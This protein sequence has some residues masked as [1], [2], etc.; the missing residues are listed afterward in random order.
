MNDREQGFSPRAALD[1]ELAHLKD[2][3][4]R[5]GDQVDTALVRAVNALRERD[6]ETAH[7]IISRDSEINAMRFEVEE[8]CLG[9][10]ATQQPAAS[11]L[12]AIVAAMNMVNDL[13]RMGDHAVGISKAVIRMQDDPPLEIP[14]EFTRIYDLA[15][16]MLHDALLSYR[17]QDL[18]LARKVADLDDQIDVHYRKLFRD[19]LAV[20]ARSPESSGAAVRLQFAS[21]NLERIADRSTNLV[22]RVIFLASGEMEELNPEPDETGLA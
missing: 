17:D 8:R 21:H 1:H 5:M 16:T 18:K 22:E 12:R 11:D 6:A 10:I 19:L 15:R 7:E 9:L 13:E 2:E 4:L 3:I 14:V 20:M